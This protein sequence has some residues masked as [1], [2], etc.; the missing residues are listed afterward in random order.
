MLKRKGITG[1][2]ISR[3]RVAQLSREQ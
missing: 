3:I 1:L 2:M